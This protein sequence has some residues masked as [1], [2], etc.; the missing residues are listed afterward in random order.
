[1]RLRRRLRRSAAVAAAVGAALAAPALGAGAFGPVAVVDPDW[2]P[3]GKFPDSSAVLGVDGAGNPVWATFARNAAG[4][5]QPAVYERCGATWKRTLLGTPAD[6]FSGYGVKV[7]RD[8]TAMAL[9]QSDGAHY[10][11]VRPPG[12]AWGGAQ[13]LPADIDVSGVQF[14]L[15]DDGR[16]IAVWTDQSP[17]GTWA[18]LRAANGTWGAPQKVAVTARDFAV[19]MSPDGNAVVLAR[20]LFPGPLVSYY[21]PAGG[22][23]SGPETVIESGYPDTMKSLMVAF[24]GLGRTVAVANY[25]ELNDTIRINV[26]TAGAWGPTDRL[27]DDDGAPPN[28]QFDMRG[29][30]ALVRHPQGAVAVWT[31][32]GGND[33]IVVSR[34]GAGGWEDPPRVFDPG[35]AVGSVN[36]AVDAAGEILLAGQL[37]IGGASEVQGTIA[38]SLTAAWPELARLSPPS[39]ETYEPRD[40]IVGGGGPAFYLGWGVHG[41]GGQR[42]EIVST[43]SSGS[44]GATAT[45]SP[46]ATAAAAATATPAATAAP[47]PAPTPAPKP[48]AKAAP[49][50]IADFTTLPAASKCVRGRKLTL[51]LKRPPKGYVVKRVTVK[52]NKKTVATLTGKRLKRPLHLR[53]LPARAFTVTV[54]IKPSKGKTLTERRRYRPCR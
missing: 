8:G 40:A 18:S 13:P 19:D 26:G 10:A 29:L 2:W 11:S 21:R 42:S 36:A 34:I 45:P 35:A 32:G 22:A 38:P 3:G 27:I 50:A 28:P 30:K 31:R 53:R 49:R 16:A 14:A 23:W 46:T 41:A 51:R 17:L 20:A 43:A 24:D 15:S 52:V 7:G 5:E 1:M 12:G 37:V 54:S 47:L 6:S 44:C 39:T 48:N 33:D 25:R 9:W 4:R